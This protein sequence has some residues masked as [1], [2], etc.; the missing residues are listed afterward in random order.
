[1]VAR[2]QRVRCQRKLKITIVTNFV[3][4]GWMEHAFPSLG[5]LRATS[6]LRVRTSNFAYALHYFFP[7]WGIISQSEFVIF[8]YKTQ[9]N[10]LHAHH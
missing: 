6:V 4:S 7:V 1:V 3:C 9:L 2:Y 8:K 5:T 10:K